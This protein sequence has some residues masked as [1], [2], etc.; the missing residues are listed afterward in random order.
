MSQRTLK[1]VPPTPNCVS[2]QAPESDTEHRAEPVAFEGTG[3]DA[4]AAVR[5]VVAAYP[6]TQVEVDEP[7]YLH[8]VCTTR[9][10]RFKDDVE[11]LVDEDAKLIHYRSASRV[12]SSDLGA[13]RARMEEMTAS[14]R[15]AL[16]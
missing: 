15:A 8:A 13:N 1:S 9:I 7:R 10:M 4:M 14:I 2:T 3:E 11:F 12:G 5:K 16:G 6:R